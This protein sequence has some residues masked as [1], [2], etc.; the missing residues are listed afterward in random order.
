MK[1]ILKLFQIV[2]FD[3]FYIS[4]W[5]PE[6]NVYEC[7]Q[8]VLCSKAVSCVILDFNSSTP[9]TWKQEFNDKF[10]KLNKYVE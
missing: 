10:F 8:E 7:I 3:P 4:P 9:E 5:L 1:T 6:C 2:L